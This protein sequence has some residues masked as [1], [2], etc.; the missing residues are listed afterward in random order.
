LAAGASLNREPT[1]RSRDAFPALARGDRA[2]PFRIKS[3]ARPLVGMVVAME[4]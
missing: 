4:K 1:V 2:P 3:L